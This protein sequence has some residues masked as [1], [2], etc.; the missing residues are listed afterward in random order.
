M[1][2]NTTVTTVPAVSD[3]PIEVALKRASRA[4]VEL[5]EKLTA[6]GLLPP[7]PSGDAAVDDFVGNLKGA[8]GSVEVAHRNTKKARPC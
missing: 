7:G 2:K 3:D 6:R 4:L 8:L 5:T 1:T